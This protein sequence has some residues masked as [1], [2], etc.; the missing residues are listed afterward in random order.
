MKLTPTRKKIRSHIES[1]IDIWINGNWLRGAMRIIIIGIGV[2]LVVDGRHRCQFWHWISILFFDFVLF[3]CLFLVF[4]FFSWHC[5]VKA[6]PKWNYTCV[7]FFKSAIVITLAL[8]NIIII[9]F[10]AFKVCCHF[11][12]VLLFIFACINSHYHHHIII[13]IIIWYDS[14]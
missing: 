10:I 13:I 14:P 5:D 3:V 4:S 7:W 11:F 1:G 12:L 9:I 2:G 6:D 8:V